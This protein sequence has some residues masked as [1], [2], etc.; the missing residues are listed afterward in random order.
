MNASEWIVVLYSVV[1]KCSYLTAVGRGVLRHFQHVR[2]NRGPHKKG[3]GKFLQH[4]NMPEIIEIIIGKRFC[5]AHWHHKVWS[6][7]LPHSL[8]YLLVQRLAHVTVR[9]VWIQ[10]GG[11]RILGWGPTFFLNRAL[12]RLNPAVGSHRSCGKLDD[13]KDYKVCNELL[14][15][16]I[17]GWAEEW[18]DVQ[19]PFGKLR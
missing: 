15:L 18:R 4:S 3:T 2:P 11:I 5:V 8:A 12:L 16:L 6:Q 10:S 13:T 17:V 14:C 9:V 1:H 7:V 19:R